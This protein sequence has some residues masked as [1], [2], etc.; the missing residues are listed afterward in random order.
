MR[1]DTG[2]VSQMRIMPRRDAADKRNSSVHGEF[3]KAPATR[4]T[5]APPKSAQI[6]QMTRPEGHI[7]NYIGRR[8]F[9]S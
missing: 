2:H 9:L 6:L 8:N 3:S 1:L 5:I 7:A 4:G